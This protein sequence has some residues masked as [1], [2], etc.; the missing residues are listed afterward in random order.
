M[1]KRNLVFSRLNGRLL[2]LALAVLGLSSENILAG[3]VI[4]EGRCL[5][6][7]NFASNNSEAK[8]MADWAMKCKLISLKQYKNLLEEIKED[9]SVGPADPASFPLIAK[10]I[11]NDQGKEDWAYIAVPKD[12][13]APCESVNGSDGELLKDASGVPVWGYKGGCRAIGCYSPEQKI[14]FEDGYLSIGNAEKLKKTGVLVLDKNS[15]LENFQYKSAPV[16]K[17]RK[18]LLPQRQEIYTFKTAANKT[19]RITPTHPMLLDDGF[20]WAAKK[21]KEGQSFVNADGTFDKI[22]RATKELE[23]VETVNIQPVSK[24]FS[25]NLLLVEGL[26]TGSLRYQDEYAKYLNRL[27]LRDMFASKS[28]KGN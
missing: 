14:A 2:T 6:S 23:L 26:V 10:N 19:I 28:E 9:G 22:V 12:P 16:Q 5:E 27:A 11:I 21:I 8:L 20:L 24:Q 15:T 1:N 17:Y 25:E 13:N 3:P 7:G 4:T 18:D